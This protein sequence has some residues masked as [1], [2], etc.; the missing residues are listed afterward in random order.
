MACLDYS[1]LVG[2]PAQRRFRK[3]KLLLFDRRLPHTKS[4]RRSVKRRQGSVWRVEQDVAIDANVEAVAN[5]D[6]DCRLYV[7]VTP[8]D[9]GAEIRRLL[10]HCASSNLGWAWIREQRAV[11]VL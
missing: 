9:L 7:Q 10:A 3:M 6:F 11:L 5:G 1:R 2:E 8:C 4:I